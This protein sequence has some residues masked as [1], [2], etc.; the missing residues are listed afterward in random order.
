VLIDTNVVLDVLLDRSPFA[1][2]ASRLMALIERR[3]VHGLLGATTVTTLHYLVAKAIGAKR[4]HDTIRKLLMLFEI[5]PVDQR[6]LETA[7]TLGFADFEDA[8]LCAAAQLAQA[9][10]IVSRDLAGF[11][12]AA[13]PVY[14]PD[15]FLR[16]SSGT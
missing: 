13:L 1:E 5:A 7:L 8:V 12:K 15:E 4:A 9:K 16:I 2:P 6:V 14:T 10:G 11:K 3:Q